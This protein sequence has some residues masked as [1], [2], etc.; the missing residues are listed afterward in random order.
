MGGLGDLHTHHGV[1]IDHIVYG[2]DE[3]R[4]QS[5]P[6][7]NQAPVSTFLQLMASNLRALCQGGVVLDGTS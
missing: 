3:P 2:C 6:P 5:W 7:Q 1:Q 4:V